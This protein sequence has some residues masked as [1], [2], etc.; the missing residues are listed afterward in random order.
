MSGHIVVD[1]L[2]GYIM[3]RSQRADIQGTVL[4][5]QT[6]PIADTAIE[7]ELVI[8]QLFAQVSDQLL[9]LSS[10]NIVRTV[11]QNGFVR[12][13]WFITEGDQIAAQGNIRGF[14][15]NADTAS[16]QRRTPRVILEWIIAQNG[17]IC[18]IAARLHAVRNR[19][20]HANL[21]GFRHALEIWCIGSLQR[22]LISKL[23]QRIIRHTV[24]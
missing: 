23:R 19:L 20:D 6:V 11:V 21:R 10:G 9:C 24:K 2:A 4:P 22:G 3:G 17:Q 16:L 14:H 7:M 13:L 8:V 5:D 1:G 12:I 18:H 15:I